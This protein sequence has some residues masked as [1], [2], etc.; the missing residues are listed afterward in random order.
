MWYISGNR[1][2]DEFAEP[3]RFLLGRDNYRKHIA[4]GFGVHR[5]VGNRLAELQ[6]RVLWEEILARDLRIEVVGAPKRQYSTFVHG[7][8]ELPVVIRQ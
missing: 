8:V 6:L 2:E 4:F 7:I 5:C 1:D 3:H